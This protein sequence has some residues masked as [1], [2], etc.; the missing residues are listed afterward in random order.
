MTELFDLVAAACKPVNSD[1]E[2]VPVGTLAKMADALG[3][4]K[5]MLVADMTRDRDMWIKAWAKVPAL[6]AGVSIDAARP[7]DGLKTEMEDGK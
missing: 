5:T 4:L 3:V 2:V 7:A 1:F 6:T